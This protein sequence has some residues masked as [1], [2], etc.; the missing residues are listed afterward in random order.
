MDAHRGDDDIAFFAATL[1]R[2]IGIACSAVAAQIPDEEGALPAGRYLLHIADVTPK[3]A[4]LWV[5]TGKFEEAVAIAVAA[6][7]PHFPMHLAGIV[8]LEL[9]VRRGF[10]DR[11]AA[12]M[13]VGTGTLYITKISTEA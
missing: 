7:P 2:T 6:A 10:N 12:I 8:A 3:V 4:K 13:S 9:N 1:G 5:A 11:I